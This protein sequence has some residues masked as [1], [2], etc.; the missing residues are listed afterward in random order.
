M[1]TLT[2]KWNG[3]NP[4]VSTLHDV[5]ARLGKPS[6]DSAGVAYGPTQNLRMLSY[7]NP[8]VSVFLKPDNLVL[9]IIIIPRQTD[10]YPFSAVEWGNLLG[11]PQR[12]LPSFRGKNYQAHVYSR[13]GLAPTFN[14]Q[15]RLV[16]LELFTTPMGPDDYV[17]AFYKT[18][19]KFIK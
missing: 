9:L 19:P 6:R 1:K 3:L 14:E 13:T 15:E 16:A 11:K 4:G 2:N 7:D 17:R 10:G 18:P 12:I 5:Q 8:Q